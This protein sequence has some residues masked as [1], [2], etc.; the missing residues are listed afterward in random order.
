LAKISGMWKT[1]ALYALALAAGVFALS[2]LEIAFVSRAFAPQITLGLVGLA[3]AALGVWAGAKLTQRAP[4]GP[5]E[6]NTAALAALGVSARE[7]DVLVELA[8]GRSNKEIARRLGV[9]PNTVKTHV[10]RLY[11]KLEVSRR[12]QAV[13]KARRLALIP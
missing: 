8:A 11:E 9:S 1:A 2:W 7:Y 5:F 3:F 13:D 12:M 4:A 6:R 10:A